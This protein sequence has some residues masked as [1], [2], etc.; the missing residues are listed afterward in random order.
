MPTIYEIKTEF[1]KGVP[2]YD[3]DL[4][5]KSIKQIKGF[6]EKTPFSI[7]FTLMN[8]EKRYCTFFIRKGNSFETLAEEIVDIIRGLGEI[9]S[10]ETSENGYL[11]IW[12]QD[13][14]EVFMYALFDYTGGVVEVL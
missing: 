13:K 3:E 14:Q 2:S 4:L 12:V 8:W 1:Y 5:I 7:Y 6:L 11:E 10:I 9:K